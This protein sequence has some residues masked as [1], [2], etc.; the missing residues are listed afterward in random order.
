MWFIEKKFYLVFKRFAITYK[1]ITFTVG[2]N[3]FITVITV[4]QSI[5][6]FLGKMFLA[7]MYF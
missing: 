4:L 5:V 7:K 6:N 1:N 3:L 2:I